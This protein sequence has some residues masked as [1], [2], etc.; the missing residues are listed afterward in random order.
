MNILFL[1]GDT[2]DVGGDKVLWLEAQGHAV[3]E[4]RWPGWGKYTGHD[5]REITYT[6]SITDQVFDVAIGSSYGG[7]LLHLL[8]GTG[9]WRGPAILMAPALELNG[10]YFIDHGDRIALIHDPADTVCA[11]SR[12]AELYRQLPEHLTR[13]WQGS[14]GGHRL[15]RAVCPE[16]LGEAINWVTGPLR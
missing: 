12:T 7:A 2:S 14:Y 16:V 9:F 10:H 3:T 13:L 1:R 8:L 6:D 4:P 15:Q 5:F 11:Y